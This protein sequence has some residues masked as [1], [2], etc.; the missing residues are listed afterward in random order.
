MHA[1]PPI[2]RENEYGDR[3]VKCPEPLMLRRITNIL[4]LLDPP[5]LLVQKRRQALHEWYRCAVYETP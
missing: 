2:T 3:V 1:Y 4:I 5:G